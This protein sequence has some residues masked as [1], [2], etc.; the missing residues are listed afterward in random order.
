MNLKESGEV[1][2]EGFGGREWKGEIYFKN[3]QN[4]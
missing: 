4:I 3:K 1:Y 2:M